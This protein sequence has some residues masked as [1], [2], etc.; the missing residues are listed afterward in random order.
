MK[1]VSNEHFIHS[2]RAPPLVDCIHILA[3]TKKK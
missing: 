1:F 2:H 3:A